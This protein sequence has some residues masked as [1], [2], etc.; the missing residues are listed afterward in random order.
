MTKKTDIIVLAAAIGTGAMGGVFFAFSAFIMSGLSRLPHRQGIAAM[1]SINVTAVRPPLMLMLFGTAALCVAI[2]VR[3]KLTW[4]DRRATLLLVGGLL[5]LVGVVVL[6]AAYNVPLNNRLALLHGSA[7]DAAAQ[8]HSYVIRWT[9]ANTVR[10]MTSLGAS[11]I[12]I[13]ALL[14]GRSASAPSAGAVRNHIVTVA[15]QPQYQSVRSLGT[16]VTGIR[17]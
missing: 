6:T 8:W 11:A 7:P 10:A 9:L 2:L 13:L 3:A 5:Y 4:G 17:G 14:D 16:P 1:Q 15:Q 12:L